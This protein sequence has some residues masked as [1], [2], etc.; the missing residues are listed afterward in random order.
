MQLFP[1]VPA[2][3]LSTFSCGHVIPSSN[4]QGLVLGKGPRGK[5]LSFTFKNRNDQQTV[6]ARDFLVSKVNIV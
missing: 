5:E 6:R 3:R 1:D 2:E 4:L